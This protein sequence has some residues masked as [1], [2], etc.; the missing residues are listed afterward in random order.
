VSVFDLT[1]TA[2][3]ADGIVMATVGVLGDLR[4]LRL[5]PRLYRSRDADALAAEIV[6]TV[7]S[8]A[9]C[10]AQEA[11]HAVAAQLPPGTDPEEADLLFGPALHELERPSGT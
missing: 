6:A 7:R 3:S 10:A 2:G 1:A 8:A 5:D 4:E 9:K 11:F